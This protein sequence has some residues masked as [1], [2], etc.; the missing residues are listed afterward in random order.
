MPN[1]EKA[2]P[3]LAGSLSLPAGVMGY[4]SAVGKLPDDSH[5]HLKKVRMLGHAISG[6]LAV[7]LAVSSGLIGSEFGNKGILLSSIPAAVISYMASRAFGKV[8]KKELMEADRLI[9]RNGGYLLGE[10]PHGDDLKKVS[11]VVNGIYLAMIGG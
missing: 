1:F 6:A 2:L 4:R 10:E 7:P 5:Q 9:R 11:H 3:W 8:H